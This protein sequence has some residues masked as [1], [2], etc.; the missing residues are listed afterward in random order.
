MTALTSS[1]PCEATGGGA[2]FEPWEH[3][4]AQEP[5]ACRAASA[6]GCGTPPPSGGEPYADVNITDAAER[7]R[8]LGAEVTVW[9]ERLDPAI[10]LATAFP[11]AAAAAER[12]W[13][14]RSLVLDENV[15]VARLNKASC[16]VLERRG[17]RGG[18]AQPGFCPWSLDW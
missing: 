18:T 2:G 11:R 13:S 14:P 8:V 9:G 3:V 1:K 10:M 4:Y 7:A 16:Q 6:Q 17:V 5:F 12:L 15:T